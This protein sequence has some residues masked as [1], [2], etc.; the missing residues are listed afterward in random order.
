MTKMITQSKSNTRAL[1]DPQECKRKPQGE[2]DR[3]LAPAEKTL[4]GFGRKHTV[5]E[6]LL[7]IY[8]GSGIP[9][10]FSHRKMFLVNSW[11]RKSKGK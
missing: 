9:T 5:K 7:A 11:I 4:L 10:A 6:G 8:E 3:I 1:E 2:T